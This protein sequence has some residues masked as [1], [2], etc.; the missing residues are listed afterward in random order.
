MKREG[1]ERR[2]GGQ[3]GVCGLRCPPPTHTH[4]QG[5][6][7]CLRGAG[8]GDG[9]FSPC[10]QRAG[11]YSAA[12]KNTHTRPADGLTVHRSRQSTTS[13]WVLCNGASFARACCA[14]PVTEPSPLARFCAFAS[15][16]FF[17]DRRLFPHPLASLALQA[18]TFAA[19][20]PAAIVKVVGRFVI[21]SRGNPT[22]EAD[23]SEFD[24]GRGRREKEKRKGKKTCGPRLAVRGVVKWGLARRARPSLQGGISTPCSARSRGARS[25]RGRGGR[26]RVEGGTRAAAQGRLRL[27]I[28]HHPNSPLLLQPPTRAPSGRPSP[29]ARPPASTKLSSCGTAAMRESVLRRGEKRGSTTPP[30]ADLPPRARKTYLGLSISFLSL[31]LAPHTA[32]WARA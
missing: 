31:S 28:A 29:L 7:A 5:S 30:P 19:M 8:G 1:V 26:P 24:G 14:R 12:L 27:S 3:L 17:F 13:A 32:T 9:T 10:A 11:R 21:D 6:R 4:L 23:V 16:P 15:T 22:V 18:K 20:A 25:K 2:R